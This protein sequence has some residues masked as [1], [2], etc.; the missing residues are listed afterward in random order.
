MLI[1][2]HFKKSKK[3]RKLFAE[4]KMAT[5]FIKNKKKIFKIKEEIK[6]RIKIKLNN[7]NIKI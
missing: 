5:N 6:I 4:K 2:K 7:N 3:I 1:S